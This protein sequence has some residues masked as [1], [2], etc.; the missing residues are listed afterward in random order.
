[1]FNFSDSPVPVRVDIREA[2]V[3]A[4]RHFAKPGPA[5]DARQRNQV[6]SIAR[7]PSTN[8]GAERLVPESLLELASVLYAD[9]PA[10]ERRLV[11]SAVEH[12]GD[13]ATVESIGLIAMLAAVDGGHR[14]LGVELEALPEPQPGE[15]TGRVATGLRRRRSHV[16]MPKG[17]IPT[18][19]DLVPD[20]G[21]AYRSMFGP[22]YM[23][24]DEMESPT[25]ARHPGLNRAQMELMSS[26]TSL[27]NECF[28]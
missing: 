8:Q 4:W 3:G 2:C 20:V 27:I 23:T 22:F 13:P 9:P 17:G 21:A 19:L 16:P 26:R 11:R 24:L 18:A 5:L 28:Y 25:F 15:P 7:D 1:M 12:A 14:A 10:L 6:L